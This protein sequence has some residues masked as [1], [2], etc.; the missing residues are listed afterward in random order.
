MFFQ[1]QS[2]SEQ[3]AGMITVTLNVKTEE[4]EKAYTF[5]LEGEKAE[6]VERVLLASDREDA[7]QKPEQ[8]L[9]EALLGGF[10]HIIASRG[11]SC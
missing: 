5:T 4:A 6:T 7:P 8:I 2:F 3:E 11:V 1:Q 9:E 10:R